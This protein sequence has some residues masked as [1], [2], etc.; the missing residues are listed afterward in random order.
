MNEIIHFDPQNGRMAFVIVR[1]QRRPRD[2]GDFVELGP[3]HFRADAKTAPVA[4]VD[5]DGVAAENLEHV[6]AEDR[7]FVG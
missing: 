4:R 3:H 2:H 6:A 7:S 1:L 5:E